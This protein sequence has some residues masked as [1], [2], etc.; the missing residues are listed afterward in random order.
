MVAHLACDVVDVDVGVPVMIYEI[1]EWSKVLTE[2]G[3]CEVSAPTNHV[4]L[5]ILRI[6]KLLPEIYLLFRYIRILGKQVFFH[7][8]NGFQYWTSLEPLQVFYVP[9]ER[10]LIECVWENGDV[11]LP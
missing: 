2:F 5:L 10:E 11:I 6:S 3:I 9:H 1:D 4:D 8:S 7:F